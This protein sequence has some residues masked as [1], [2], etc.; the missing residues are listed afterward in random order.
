MRFLKM[1]IYIHAYIYLHIYILFLPVSSV[2]LLL[3]D[4][5]CLLSQ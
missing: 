2:N 3:S 5:F 1:Y 4:Y